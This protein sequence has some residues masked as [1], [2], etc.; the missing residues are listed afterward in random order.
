MTFIY[1]SYVTNYCSGKYTVLRAKAGKPVKLELKS[2]HQN[3]TFF[4]RDV[5][6]FSMVKI[7]HSSE[8]GTHR[9]N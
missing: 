6:Y 7:W 4:E 9:N 8:D 3:K 5:L 1:D 2:S